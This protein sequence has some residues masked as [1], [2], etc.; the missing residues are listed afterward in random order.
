MLPD[1]AGFKLKQL[2]LN[3]NRLSYFRCIKAMGGD[4]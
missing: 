3:K 4:I 1:G 2:L